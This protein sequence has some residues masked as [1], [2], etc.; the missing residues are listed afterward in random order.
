MEDFIFENDC[1]KCNSHSVLK[2]SNSHEYSYDLESHQ[3]FSCP[4][5]N[6]ECKHHEEKP[7]EEEHKEDEHKEEK[8]EEKP[9]EEEKKPSLKEL[10][11]MHHKK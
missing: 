1:L 7:K 11:L 9:K 3:I 2:N 5:C 10:Y 4:N 8:H 6:K